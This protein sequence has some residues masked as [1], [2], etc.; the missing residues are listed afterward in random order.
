MAECDRRGV[1]PRNDSDLHQR[2]GAT[3][4]YVTHDKGEAIDP[5]L[6]GCR[7]LPGSL[8]AGIRPEYLTLEPAANAPLVG[9]VRTVEFLGSRSL[10]RADIGDNLVTAFVSPEIDLKPDQPVG[11]GAGD[12]R[13]VRLFDGR[14][15]AA[16]R[17]GNWA[18]ATARMTPSRGGRR[19]SRR[20]AT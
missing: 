10:V 11:L 18:C 7:D 5:L 20:P 6:E 15:G 1:T 17:V 9:K 14:S 13:K 12:P 3:M 19:R 8:C 4:L 2:L 16:I